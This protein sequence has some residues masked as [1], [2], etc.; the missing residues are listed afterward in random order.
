MRMVSRHIGCLL[1][2]AALAHATDFYVSP[3][4]DDSHSG[5][6]SEPLRTLSGARN[7]VRG[8][9][10]DLDEPVTVYFRGGRYP[11]TRMVEFTAQDS[12]T[13]EKPVTYQS[14]PNERP[15][16]SGGV[17][18]TGW[19][20]HDVDKNMYR[21]KAPATMFRQ[22]YINQDRG[23]RARTPNR[24][25]ETS[26]GPYWKMQ[27]PEKP[28]ALISDEHW[29]AVES[30]DDLSA[31]EI[32]M[33]IHW[34]QQRLRIGA[35]SH[36]AEGVRVTPLKPAGKFNKGIR[37]YDVPVFYFENDP[38]FLDAPREWFHDPESGLVF[39]VLEDG[40]HPRDLE[41]I[42]PQ[43]ET[44]ISIQGSAEAPVKNLRFIGLTLEH[45]NWTSPSVNGLNVTQFAQPNAVN[46]DGE[47]PDYPQAVIR[48]IHAENL[49]L[50]ENT[51]RNAGASGIQFLANV[52]RADIEGNVVYNIAANG[53]EIDAHKMENAPPELKSTQ[54]AIWNN[55][56]SRCGQDYTNGGGILAHNVSEL[57]IEHNHVFNMPYS[58]IQVGNQPGGEGREIGCVNNRIRF[59]HI[60][61]CLQLHDDGGGIY[62]LGGVQEG[63]VIARNHIHDIVPTY[64]TGRYGIDL[65]YLDN[66]T[67]KA[68]V[69]D[70]VV[71]GGKAEERNGSEGN[72]LIN[73]TQSNPE[74][75]TNAGIK[76][77]YN[78]RIVA[79]QAAQDPRAASPV[80]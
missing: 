6:L 4:G 74:V 5:S 65:I 64:L 16:I 13:K 68:L 31:I 30:I 38:T 2:S 32:V 42:A 55:R 28:V 33:P 46:P 35:H 8:L 67:S 63:T 7:L 24:E 41:I 11:L 59:N 57:I 70:N 47:N 21:A 12:G 48:A 53:I 66:F 40:V 36:T 71:N 27:V 43:L 60:H 39:L 58:G 1:L 78:P 61:H 54:V 72:T 62:T 56:I 18:I 44:L 51:I 10:S 3:D 34:Y 52:D 17:R 23:I 49:V 26:F 29:K 19:E 37:F 22:L 15:V 79:G 69:K 75:E 9:H 76:P 80:R 25:S 45:S 20:V 14:F 73:N 50:R 77:D